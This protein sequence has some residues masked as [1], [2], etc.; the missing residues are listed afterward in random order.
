MTTLTSLLAFNKLSL[1][2]NTVSMTAILAMSTFGLAPLPYSQAVCFNSYLMCIY[3]VLI[4]VL[5]LERC[6]CCRDDQWDP[7]SIFNISAHR[8][9]YS[10][11]HSWNRIV[12]AGEKI[13]IWRRGKQRWHL[14]TIVV[15]FFVFKKSTGLGPWPSTGYLQVSWCWWKQKNIP[16]WIRC[17]GGGRSTF[18]RSDQ[19]SW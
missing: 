13:H 15:V 17:N 4:V 11:V 16:N 3:V 8:Q 14:R 18:K 10:C 5:F 19:C 9:Q 7:K 2:L 6:G 1:S 12:H